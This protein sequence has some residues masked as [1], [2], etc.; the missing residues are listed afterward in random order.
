[1]WVL[2]R[3]KQGL[4]EDGSARGRARCVWEGV[5]RDLPGA[6]HA[7]LGWEWGWLHGCEPCCA[8]G[9]EDRSRLVLHTRWD[10]AGAVLPLM[11][12]AVILPVAFS[13][14][15]KS[16]LNNCASKCKE[17]WECWA[18]LGFITAVERVEEAVFQGCFL[19][20][21]LG[22]LVFPGSMPGKGTTHY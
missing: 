11:V 9:P 5:P 21:V 6:G 14:R 16:R 4:A 13:L 19:W 12:S 7:L 10:S 15:W 20:V 22:L 1:M 18:A 3:T 2:A 17:A 8:S